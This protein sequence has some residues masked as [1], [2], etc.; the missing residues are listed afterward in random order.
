MW[1]W[2]TLFTTFLLTNVKLNQ[3]FSANENMD[4]YFTDRWPQPGTNPTIDGYVHTYMGTNS[5]CALKT[6]L[7]SWTCAYHQLWFARN[8]L[9]R[10]PM[11]MYLSKK[12]AVGWVQGVNFINVRTEMTVNKAIMY[13]YV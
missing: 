5:T 4:P 9:H 6:Y 10:M 13:V 7:P 1:K 12:V 8:Y 2:K 11:M 3:F